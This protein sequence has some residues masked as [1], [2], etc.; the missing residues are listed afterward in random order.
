MRL[1]TPKPSLPT[2]MRESTSVSLI[3]TLPPVR[4]VS[5]Y[6]QHLLAA[7]STAGAS[8]DFI[9]FRSIYPRW[10]FPGGETHERGAVSPA[11]PGVRMRHN[12]RWY[13][14]LGWVIAGLTLRGEVVHAQWWSYALAPV[15]VVV[16]GLA[17]LRGKRVLL[18]VH[19][20]SP[21]EGG[22]VRRFLNRAVFRLG[23]HYVVHSTQNRDELTRISAR[24][25]DRIDVL[26]HGTLGVPRAG[27]SREEARARLGLPDT[28]GAR[29]LLAFGHIRPYKGVD[30]LLR[31][32]ADVAREDPDV[33][34]VIAG[35]PW[36]SFDRYARLIE[37]LGLGGRVRTYLDFIATD[38]VEAFF[39]AADVVVLPY[40]DF[41]SQSG[42]GA[43]ALHFG[44]P[45]V[46][47]NVGGLAELVRD[48]ACIVP[49]RHTAALASALARMLADHDLRARCASDSLALA[50]AYSWDA[51]ASDTIA[52][53]RWLLSPA[54][55][56]APAYLRRTTMPDAT[57]GPASEE[58]RVPV[59]AAGGRR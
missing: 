19:N 46:V 24:S 42:V 47:T 20:V 8:V 5:P 3:G 48:P 27:L 44:R 50:D 34:L 1:T 35:N 18:T 41:Q 15:Y 21:H 56:R 54:P 38:N 45:L 39:E 23:H 37:E 33:T 11:M 31:A 43:L 36:G 55:E 14:P 53:Y 59:E 26:P 9:G 10:A 25:E 4:G 22:L 52:L 40:T 6:T 28:P 12:L 2:P 29:V 7:L 16:L 30:V 13:N 57:P 49:P 51:I 58:P 32:F 17:R